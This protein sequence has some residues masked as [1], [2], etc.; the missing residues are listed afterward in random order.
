MR[1][2]EWQ[3]FGETREEEGERCKVGDVQAIGSEAWVL[4]D[5]QVHQGEA[6]SVLGVAAA[7]TAL[8]KSGIAGT[9]RRI[10][11]GETAR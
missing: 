7:E 6:T 5:P 1:V 3:P 2:S 4:A 8:P 10:L 11:C 9:G